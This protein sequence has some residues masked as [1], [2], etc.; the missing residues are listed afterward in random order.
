M[1]TGRSTSLQNVLGASF[2]SFPACFAVSLSSPFLLSQDLKCHSKKGL[3]L[4]L[5]Q[6][7]YFV[8]P[9]EFELSWS[10]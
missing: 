9:A 4:R 3:D 7:V 1:S 6:L 2:P 8:L 5:S 10:R